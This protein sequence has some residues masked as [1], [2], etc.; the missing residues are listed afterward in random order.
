M[1]LRHSGY[2]IVTAALAIALVSCGKKEDTT[3][4]TPAA[5]T[6][7][8]GQPVDAATAGSITGTIKLDGTAPTPGK[9]SMAAEAYCAQQHPTPVPAEDVVVGPGGVLAN[10]VVYISDD[11]SKYAVTI[12]ST[13]AT[14]DQKGCMY[15]PHVVAMVAGQQLQITNSDATT[16]NIHPLPK[17]NA[18]WNV[19]QPPGS[20]PMMKT[21]GRPED[22]IAVKC[23]VHPWMKSYMFAFKNNFF[24]VT[25]A[26]GKYSIANV[27]PGTYTVTVWQEKY[28]NKTTSVTVPAKGT[29]TGDVS[30]SAA[31]GD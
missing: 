17:D 6:A 29:A 3:S 25:G 26:D 27:P 22:A 2:I 30:F 1:K 12:S 24:A 7:P 16:H 19:S 23:N 8:A 13:P 15:H 31:S 9:I 4:E 11:M 20:A 28:G 21:W 14:I 10:A 18:E 5:T